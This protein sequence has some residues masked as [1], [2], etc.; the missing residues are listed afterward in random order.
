MAQL[1]YR[2]QSSDPPLSLPGE[3]PSVDALPEANRFPT[4]HCFGEE[5]QLP[6][7]R[8]TQVTCSVEEPRVFRRVRVKTRDDVEISWVRKKEEMDSVSLLGDD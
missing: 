2:L 5:P 4:E 6:P 3:L 8:N 7:I 1:L